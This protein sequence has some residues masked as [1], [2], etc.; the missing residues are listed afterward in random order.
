MVM[1]SWA[2]LTEESKRESDKRGKSRER[3]GKV[4]MRKKA[5][6]DSER[7]RDL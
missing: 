2:F 4:L 7:E 1:E 6:R 3:N 5:D